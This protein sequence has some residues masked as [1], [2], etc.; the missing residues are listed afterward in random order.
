MK[1]KLT[2]FLKVEGHTLVNERDDS[3]SGV[4]LDDCRN[5]CDVKDLHFFIDNYSYI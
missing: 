1:N 5:A 4:Q 2:H 3:S